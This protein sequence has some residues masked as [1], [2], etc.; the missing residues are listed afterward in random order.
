MAVTVYIFSNYNLFPHP[1]TTRMS[2]TK[3]VSR[4]HNNEINWENH[5]K[6]MREETNLNMIL[7][8]PNEL[9]EIPTRFIVI[10]K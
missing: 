1:L 2:F 4:L 6:K 5:R 7:K 3:I 8:N 9:E 10:L